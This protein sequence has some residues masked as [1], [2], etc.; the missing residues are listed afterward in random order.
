MNISPIR[1]GGVL[2]HYI[3]HHTKYSLFL[4]GTLISFAFGASASA[5]SVPRLQV[6]V[7]PN[8]QIS[9]IGSDLSYG[10]VLR[11]LQKKLGWV[12]E[13]PASVD[14]LRL[15]HV[16]IEA[17]EPRIAIAKLLEGTR[18]GF[19]MVSGGNN[20]KS[21]KVFIIPK[22]LSDSSAS[23]DAISPAAGNTEARTS[24]PVPD[25]IQVPSVSI[26]P[27]APAATDAKQ[28]GGQPAVPLSEAANTMGVPPGM[29]PTAVG[30]TATLPISDAA[31]IMGVPPDVL[32]RNVG[33]S[34]TL[35]LS[36]VVRMMG[37]PPGM[38]VDAVGKTTIL[39][40]PT[41]SGQH[42]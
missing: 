27:S 8:Q 6:E 5:Q 13:F 42:P 37:V 39:P 4:L 25:G 7:G 19:G 9:I 30:S 2:T 15:E 20:S 3:L 28:L 32:P 18:F 16:R 36:E 33:S 22:T 35:P 34:T 41:G 1:R 40:I 17:T 12:I 29:A 24:L 11:A 38:S 21:V 14:E 26:E 31:N 10:E 23:S